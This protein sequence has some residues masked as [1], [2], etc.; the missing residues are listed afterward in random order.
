VKFDEKHLRAFKTAAL[1]EQRWLGKEPRRWASTLVAEDIVALLP[2]GRQTRQELRRFCCDRN[3]STVACFLAIM[4]WG[5]MHLG[6]AREAWKHK[7]G[8]LCTIERLR[9]SQNSREHDYHTL[10]QLR[11]FPLHGIGPAYFTKLL[12]FLRPVQDAY[13]MDQWTAKSLQLLSRQRRPLL[14]ADHVS[15][16]NT[17]AD[18]GWFCEAVESLA[19]QTCWTPSVVEERLFSGG[20]RLRAEWREHV[21]R[22]WPACDAAI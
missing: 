11:P 18:Y 19:E 16:A 1:P 20:G 13:I 6:N 2:L 3:A 10:A 9:S 22:N 15:D 12:Y 8:W 17:H 4:S 21:I 14:R 5:G 7:A